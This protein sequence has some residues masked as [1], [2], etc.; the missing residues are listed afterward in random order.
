MLLCGLILACPPHTS[1]CDHRAP[2]PVRSANTLCTT[3]ILLTGSGW[4]LHRSQAQTVVVTAHLRLCL[5]SAYRWLQSLHT[6]TSFRFPFSTWCL[7]ETAYG[8]SVTLPPGSQLC[9]SLFCV[10][11]Q[12]QEWVD[13]TKETMWSNSGNN[14]STETGGHR[15]FWSYKIHDLYW[16]V[17]WTFLWQWHYG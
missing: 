12:E 13:H 6:A 9:W 10:L 15:Q 4:G 11:Y 3:L 1:G 2:C 14:G 8:C 7:L 17:M 16:L 5:P